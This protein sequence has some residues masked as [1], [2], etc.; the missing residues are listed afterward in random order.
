VLG[1]IY[2]GLAGM[3]SFA[4]GLNT[5][6]NNVANL[7]TP[8]FKA[9]EPL[10]SDLVFR[11]GSGAVGGSPGSGSPGA[12]VEAE[13]ERMSFR[14][15]DLRSTGNPLDVAVDGNGF[16]VLDDH[17]STFYTR[18]GQF[19]F[20]KDGN[21]VDRATGAKVMFAT[22]TASMTALDINPF[23][24][25]PPKA[26]TEVK[27]TGTLARG[28]DNAPFEVSNLTVVDTAGGKQVLKA[29]FVRDATN[30]LQWTI[31][32]SDTDGK[33]L[34]SGAV[35]FD[36]NGTPVTGSNRVNVTVTPKDL[37]TFDV[38]FSVGE[39]GTYAGVT[40]PSDNTTSQVQL[41][42]QDGVQ[43]G[44]VT[45]FEFNDQGELKLTYSNGETKSIG[46]L[47]LARFDSPDQVQ[48][49]GGGR[50]ISAGDRQPALGS[51]LTSGLG[52]IVGGQIELSNVDLT[53]Q[54][55]DLIVI[56]RGFQASS[57]MA[58]TANEMLQ[59]LIAMDSR[60]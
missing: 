39:A 56:Q 51:G 3:V 41:L 25:F 53:S 47:V 28:G 40:T 42:K 17:G 9:S 19:E 33:V 15:G 13:S 30:P 29:K 6:S 14:Q 54:F 37:P 52:R 11:S 16:F 10:F 60:R 4:R 50:F 35:T 7:N 36:V 24:V 44:S 49:V 38:A 18:A 26:T 59:Q 12:G 43:L 46:K 20:D 2:K 48:E 31:E 34:G 45:Q 58:S 27:L 1:I 57:Q 8:G 23:R 21:F 32:V 55:T 22:D 5:I